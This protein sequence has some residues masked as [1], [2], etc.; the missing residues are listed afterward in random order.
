V[1]T[2]VG[3]IL[4]PVVSTDDVTRER[5]STPEHLA[6]VDDGC[7]CVEVWEHTSDHRDESAEDGSEASPDDANGVS[8]NDT[9]EASPNDAS[10]ASPNDAN[11][12]LRDDTDDGDDE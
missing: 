1:E 5:Q 3:L 10:E 11:E 4:S 7:G 8:P 2:P 9:G 6:D 12:S